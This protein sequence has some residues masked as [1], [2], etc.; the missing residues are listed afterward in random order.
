MKKNNL[1]GLIGL[2]V[3]VAMLA[4]NAGNSATSGGSYMQVPQ[5]ISVPRYVGTQTQYVPAGQGSGYSTNYSGSNYSANKQYVEKEDFSS[6]F[7]A[8]FRAAINLLSFENTYTSDNIELAGGD[9]Y[10]AAAIFGASASF[11]KRFSESFRGE[12]E[13]G[14]PGSFSDADNLAEVVM[15][16]PYATGNLILDL[17]GESNGIYIG[18]G[19]GAALVSSELNGVVFDGITNPGAESGR[20]VTSMSPVIAGMIGYSA[21]LDERLGLDIRYRISGYQGN[22]HSRIWQGEDSLGNLENYVFET[23]MG[24][25]MSNEISVGLR[26]HF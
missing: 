25:V 4:P 24:W 1:F 17:A 15:S 10:S 9:K 7:Y 14:Y 11:G 16:A 23:E 20:K 18:I 21:G 26:Y 12:L 2:V 3:G 5:Y 13:V 6:S 19:G 22:S 8:S